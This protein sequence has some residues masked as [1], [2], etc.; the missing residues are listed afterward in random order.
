MHL[1]KERRYLRN[2]E[3]TEADLAGTE[4]LLNSLSRFIFGFLRRPQIAGTL[5]DDQGNDVNQEALKKAVTQPMADAV[6]GQVEKSHW[7]TDGSG[8]APR[9]V[10]VLTDPS[11]P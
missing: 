10:Y 4:P 11:C 6:Q 8:K 3:I 5:L 2:G 9:I 1:Q 7:I